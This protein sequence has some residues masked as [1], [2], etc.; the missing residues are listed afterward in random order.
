MTNPFEQGCDAV[1]LTRALVREG[2]MAGQEAPVAALVRAAMQKLGYDEIVTDDLGNVTGLVGPAGTPVKLLFDGHMD[3]VPASGDWSRDPFSGALEGGE[4]H[5]RGS[6]DMKGP[7]AAAICGVA[8]AA[9]S[10]RL[11]HRVAV[12]ASVMEEVIEGAAL[13]RVL[14]TH[15]PEAVVICEPSDLELKTAQRGCVEVLVHVAGIPAHAAF[16]DRGVNAIEL[17]ARAITA[18]AALE[19]PT[20]PV[21]G[22]MVLVPTDIISAPYP[23][24]SALPSR[25][26]LRYDRR[27]GVGE[28][29]EAVMQAI[30]ATLAP[31]D[32]AAFTVEVS[33]SDYQSYTGVPFRVPRDLPGWHTPEDH[34]LV[35]VAQSCLS[36]QGLSPAPGSYEFCTNGSEAAGRRGLPTIGFGPG[37]PA[38]AHIIDESISVAALEQAVTVYRELALRFGTE[39]G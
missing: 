4:I 12:S 20:D 28:T 25:V 17:A 33:A 11:R 22:K 18:L 39:A 5:G 35:R 3:V 23:S 27:T 21:L 30:R 32:P 9:R 37:R 36:A 16:P 15:A 13:A 10:G 29:A 31:I 7:L 34:P 6:T 14:D 26:S 38:D 19:M 1:S 2:A 8:E 24:I